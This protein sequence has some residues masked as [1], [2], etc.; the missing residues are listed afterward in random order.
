VILDNVAST[1]R[2][3]SGG[4]LY[5]SV[6]DATLNGN[7]VVSNTASTAEGGSGGGLCLRGVSYPIVSGN[8]VAGNTASASGTG[9]GGGVCLRFSNATLSGNT[10]VSNTASTTGTGYG[11]G[12]FLRRRSP[13]LSSNIVRGNVASTAHTGWGGGVRAELIS[14]TLINNLIADNQ[15]ATHGSGLSFSG[16]SADPTSGLL[17]HNTIARN[18]ASDDSG[19]AVYVG[20][21]TTL[22]FTNTI[23]AGHRDVGINVAAGSTATLEATLWHDNGADTGGDGAVSTGAVNVFGDPRFADID[24]GVLSNVPTDIDGD[25]RPQ[26]TGYDIG[27]DEYVTPFTVYLPLVLR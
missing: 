9:H 8:T 18:G 6:S 4:G 26:E 27:A 16:S 7:T 11:G 24:S 12:L 3:A 21:H 15:A 19:E 13:T 17:L 10:V 1:A 14:V 23:I 5:L 2:A 22:S 20:Q 25:E